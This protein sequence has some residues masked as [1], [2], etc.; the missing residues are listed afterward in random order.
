MAR[1]GLARIGRIFEL[2]AS[3]RK[4]PPAEIKRLRDTHLRPHVEPFFDWVEVEYDKVRYERGSLRSALGY[5]HRQKQAL[6]R[7]LDDGRLAL[8]NHRSERP[9]RSVAVGRKPWLFVASDD[10]AQS[11]SHIFTLVASARPHGLAPEQYLRDMIRALPHCPR[12]RF[13]ELAP[14][15]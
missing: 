5:A 3:W 7:F 11:L 15:F 6:V 13:L 14:L 2:D 1:E 8:D 10:H 9:L 12:E 4:K